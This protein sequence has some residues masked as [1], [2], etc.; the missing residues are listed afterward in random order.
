MILDGSVDTANQ[1]SED[2]ALRHY[3]NS[4]RFSLIENTRDVFAED[5]VIQK[6]IYYI[7]L[8]H[9]DVYKQLKGQD[10]QQEVDELAAALDGVQAD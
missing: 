2:S 7:S 1:L 5:V 9:Q 4:S 6:V 3:M 8:F 10:G